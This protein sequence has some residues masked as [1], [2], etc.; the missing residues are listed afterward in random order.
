[1]LQL[2]DSHFGAGQTGGCGQ[3]TY[4]GQAEAVG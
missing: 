1:M 2:A 4:D 3:L